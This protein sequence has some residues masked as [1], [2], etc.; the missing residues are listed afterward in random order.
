MCSQLLC[1]SHI[2]ASIY[3]FRVQRYTQI[4]HSLLL[5]SRKLNKNPLTI[6]RATGLGMQRHNLPSTYATMPDNTNLPIPH[7]QI[8]FNLYLSAL[9]FARTTAFWLSSSDS[10]FHLTL[11]I[12]LLACFLSARIAKLT[13]RCSHNVN[14]VGPIFHPCGKKF[15]CWITSNWSRGELVCTLIANKLIIFQF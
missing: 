15:H 5:L 2:K 11:A 9:G 13:N 12:Y 7:F 3:T 6:R 1:V 10:L 8:N 4:D 14:T